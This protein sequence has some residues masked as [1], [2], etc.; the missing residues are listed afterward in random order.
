ME[1]I[2]IAVERIIDQSGEIDA[3]D[4]P[5]SR[6][7][8]PIRH[9]VLGVGMDQSI[10]CHGAGELNRLG[11]EAKVAEDRVQSQPLPELEAD[12]NRPGRTMV[13][14]GDPTG[15]NGN[16]IGRGVWGSTGLDW[17]G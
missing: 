3:Q 16:E 11:R 8:N 15:V 2:K 1:S 17:L 12:M 6:G 7:A 4:V 9:R 5:Q 10:E 13:G 14:R